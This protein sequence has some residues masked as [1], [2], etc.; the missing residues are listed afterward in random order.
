MAPPIGKT[1][2]WMRRNT[3]TKACAQRSNTEFSLLLKQCLSNQWTTTSLSK[4]RQN[5][6]TATDLAEVKP[7]VLCRLTGTHG[8]RYRGVG[9]RLA[10][11]NL[12]EVCTNRILTFKE[13]YFVQKLKKL[14]HT[15]HITVKR[16]WD[17]ARWTTLRNYHQSRHVQ[18]R[19]PICLSRHYQCGKNELSACALVECLLE[20]DHVIYMRRNTEASHSKRELKREMHFFGVG[21]QGKIDGH[22]SPVQKHAVALHSNKSNKIKQLYF[23]QKGRRE[24]A[25]QKPEELAW[26]VPKAS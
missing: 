10:F 13:P 20:N 4:G 23:T 3:Y 24:R 11:R 14:S 15:E 7:S 17:I 5:F 22:Q 21:F 18:K 9:S 8:W 1:A 6:L 19:Q 25:K 16:S 12:I 2:V 26:Q